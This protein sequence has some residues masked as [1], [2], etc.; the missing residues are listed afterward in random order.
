VR[1]CSACHAY[2]G[3]GGELGPDLTG[4]RNQPADTLLLHIL[5]PNYDVTPGYEVTT[6]VT[7]DGREISGRLASES[8]H[9]LTLRTA[10]NT[11][12]NI[13]R[14]TLASFVVSRD[15]AMPNG[16]EQAMSREELAD[17]LAFLKRGGVAAR[18]N[19]PPPNSK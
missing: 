6:V 1:A 4:V 18:Q 17:L 14:S 12:E 10:A 9:T 5:V 19:V 7:R 13:P 11:E 15:S 2:E 16:L 3:I 8:E